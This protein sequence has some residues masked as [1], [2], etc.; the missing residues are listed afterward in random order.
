MPTSLNSAAPLPDYDNRAAD[1]GDT[2]KPWIYEK[3][4]DPERSASDGVFS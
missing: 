3:K 2:E 1:I 4:A